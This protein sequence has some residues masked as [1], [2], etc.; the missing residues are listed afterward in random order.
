MCL[1]VTGRVV[2]AWGLER[3][4]NTADV[5]DREIS[6]ERYATVRRRSRDLVA[7]SRELIETARL[8][9]DDAATACALS[10][11]MVDQILHRTRP[12]R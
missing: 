2:S 9:R 4:I 6:R 3:Q 5:E 8:T 10:R 1:P 7:V 12:A 11:E